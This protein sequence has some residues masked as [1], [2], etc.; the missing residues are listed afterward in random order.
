MLRSH[1]REGNTARNSFI[2]AKSPKFMKQETYNQKLR[3]YSMCSISLFTMNM[4][5]Y[6]TFTQILNTKNFTQKDLADIMTPI[7]QQS[8]KCSKLTCEFR[9][10]HCI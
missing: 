4:Q 6:I 10:L 9:I 1:Q 5:F 2:C 3:Q 8:Q 7:M